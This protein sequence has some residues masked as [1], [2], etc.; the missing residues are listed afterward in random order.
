MIKRLWKSFRENAG[1]VVSLIGLLGFGSAAALAEDFRQMVESHPSTA[2]L[3]VVASTCLGCFLATGSCWARKLRKVRRLA[4]CFA[5][6]SKKR[7]RMVAKALDDGEVRA[8]ALDEDAT[9]LCE[10]GILGMPPIVPRTGEVGFAI[11]PDVVLEIRGH[12]E[13]WLGM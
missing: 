6:M 3:L 1:A 11:Q 10:M 7:R 5:S 13:E 9:S 4:H 8:W 2:A 12:R